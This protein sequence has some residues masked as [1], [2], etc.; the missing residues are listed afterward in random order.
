MFKRAR[1]WYVEHQNKVNQVASFH[2]NAWFLTS[3]LLHENNTKLSFMVLFSQSSDGS[4]ANTMLLECCLRVPLAFERNR[5]TGA[6]QL[7]TSTE[8]P[9]NTKS[10]THKRHRLNAE[11]YCPQTLSFLR[12]RTRTWERLCHIFLLLCF[13]N[14]NGRSFSEGRTTGKER[15]PSNG[16]IYNTCTS[17]SWM[18]V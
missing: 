3:R 18:K 5:I 9:M 10:I 11:I 6:L 15:P 12:T 2:T 17:A 14:Y 8:M 4:M 13:F 1:V 7:I 16:K